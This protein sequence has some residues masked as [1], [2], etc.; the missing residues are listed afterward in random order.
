[1]NFGE[2]IK[3]LRIEKNWTQ[4]F[5]ASKINIS[6]P[7]LSRYE[8]GTYEPKS[9]SIV[10]DFAKLYNVSTDYLLGLNLEYNDNPNSAIVLVYGTIPA[11]VP[12]ECIE[13]ILDTEEIPV[14]WLNGDKKFFG[15]KI[16]GTSM[17]PSYLDGDTIILEKTED[18]ENGQ[19]AV[20]MVNGN[21]GTFKRVFKNENGIILQPLNPEFQPMIYT[22]KQIE[23]LPI[24]IIG[25]AKEIRR[26]I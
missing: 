18:C 21:D 26:K 4:E 12:M 19:D 8:S 25:V 5:V 20:V 11:G 10:S 24:R 17:S 16:K 15:L 1:M 23:D 2:K 3:K 14:S 6:I 22:N 9:L 13:E 7:A